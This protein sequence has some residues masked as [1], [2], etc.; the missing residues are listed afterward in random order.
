[1]VKLKIYS[2]PPAKDLTLRLPA[3]NINENEKEFKVEIAAPGLKE[4]ISR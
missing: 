3:V 4:K 1:L 2:S